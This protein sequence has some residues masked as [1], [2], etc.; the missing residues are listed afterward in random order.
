MSTTNQ[1]AELA[2]Y[3]V[4]RLIMVG[5]CIVLL[6]WKINFAKQIHRLDG[7]QVEL[8]AKVEDQAV[9]LALLAIDRPESGANSEKHEHTDQISVFATNWSLLL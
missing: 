7:P 2:A 4:L 3:S 5:R 1:P 6:K 8:K 9:I